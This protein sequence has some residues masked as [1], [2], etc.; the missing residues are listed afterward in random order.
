MTDRL[1]FDENAMYKYSAGFAGLC[2]G[3]M[4]GLGIS[5][6]FNIVILHSGLF[7]VATTVAEVL[8]L[9][10]LVVIASKRAVYFRDLG[11]KS[12]LAKLGLN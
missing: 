12:R 7:V 11:N 10:P 2:F 9:L 8:I 1:A 3:L 6:V 5:L 4:L